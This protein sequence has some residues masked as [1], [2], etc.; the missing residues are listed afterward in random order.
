MNTDDLFGGVSSD[1]D[2]QN[3][4]EKSES[5][6]EKP[7]KCFFGDSQD[8]PD[9][10]ELIKYHKEVSSGIRKPIQ[11]THEELEDKE[12][13]GP[14]KK[15]FRIGM[16]GS[17][18]IM[19]TPKR[20]VLLARDVSLFNNQ[21]SPKIPETINETTGSYANSNLPTPK[22]LSPKLSETQKYGEPTTQNQMPEADK[23]NQESSESGS[24]KY[25]KTE[26]DE[27]VD[28]I[29]PAPSASVAENENELEPYDANNESNQ[30]FIKHLVTTYGP[31]IK[32]GDG[33]KKQETSTSSEKPADSLSEVDQ[34]AHM[35][36]LILL[37]NMSTQQLEQYDAY[38]RS[39]FQKSTIR[40]LVKEFTGGMNVS[41]DS[42]ITIGALAKMLV[43]DIVEEALDIRDLK[44]DEADLPLEPHHI[45]SAYM[46]VARHGLI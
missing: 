29:K 27:D 7:V 13:K 33:V 15:K 19:E 36:R 28:E 44:E 23:E 45:R 10:D 25:P 3:F 37:G 39:R 46:K 41:D 18:G 32:T 20:Q 22:L 34:I 42:V 21:E 26:G 14:P 17:G 43:G 6:E 16:S 12:N 24:S 38:R 35:K 1:E 4:P 8:M 5:P 30:S 11:K 2:D 9:I 31:V 40:K